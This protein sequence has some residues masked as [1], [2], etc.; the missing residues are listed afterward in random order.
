MKLYDEGSSEE[1]YVLLSGGLTRVV[2]CDAGNPPAFTVRPDFFAPDGVYDVKVASVSES[3]LVRKSMDEF[4]QIIVDE[5]G[6]TT[7]LYLWD[8][9]YGGGTMTFSAG[10]GSSASSYTVEIPER[11]H[12]SYISRK[13][14][15]AYRID[16][17]YRHYYPNIH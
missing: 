17:S 15:E 9:T 11:S 4:D 5:D 6:N 10:S 13:M 12:F 8:R 2:N 1:R 16:M 7:S 3:T 14:V